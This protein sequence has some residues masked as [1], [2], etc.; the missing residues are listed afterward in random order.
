[1]RN[2]AT[3]SPA[4]VKR[5]DTSDTTLPMTVQVMSF[6]SSLPLRS[7]DRVGRLWQRPDDASLPRAGTVEA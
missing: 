2:D 1:M 3:G 7:R 5:K 4:L 6:M